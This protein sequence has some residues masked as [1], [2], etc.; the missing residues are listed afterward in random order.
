[1]AFWNRP[2]EEGRH[3]VSMRGHHFTEQAERKIE[4]LKKQTQKS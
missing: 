4:V 1:M 2:A 3:L